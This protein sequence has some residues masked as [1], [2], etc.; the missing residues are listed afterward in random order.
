[1][2]SAKKNATL[3]K[4]ILFLPLLLFILGCALFSLS[5][6]KLNTSEA[7]T[8][9]WMPILI[10]IGYMIIAIATALFVYNLLVLTCLE[11]EKRF[12]SKNWHIAYLIMS[13]VRKGAKII[14]LLTSIYFAITFS[15]L[16]IFYLNIANKI[17]YTVL[18]GSIAW[19]VL[20]ILGTIETFFYTYCNEKT[21]HDM[22]E[23][24]ALYTK[25]HI[26]KNVI[27]TL[28]IILSIAAILMV[29]DSV[30]NIGISLFASAGFLTAILGLSAQRSLGSLFSGIQLAFTQPIKLDDIVVIENELGTVEEITLSF[31]TLKLWDLRRMVVPINYFTDK[32]FQNW[33]RMATNLIGTIFLYVDYMLPLEPLRE[34]LKRI[35]KSSS[36][37]DGEK[38]EIQVINFKETNVELRVLVSATTADTLSQLRLEVREKLLEFIRKNHAD[39][40]PK[41]R[42]DTIRAPSLNVSP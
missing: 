6:I 24:K 40:F 25:V 31:V 29:F 37:W 21:V 41:Q 42:T 28:V 19:I 2:D 3:V 26:I 16:S 14:F 27:A 8:L 17:F 4:K 32:P 38:A 34:E 23:R 36:A 18:T 39:C 7:K 30:R 11:Y 20:Q 9:Y 35:V 10:N 1:M 22:R 12:A 15:G 13:I 33:S 5:L